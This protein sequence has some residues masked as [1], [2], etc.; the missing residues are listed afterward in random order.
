MVHLLSLLIGIVAGLRAMIAPAAVSWAA[1]L[2]WLR[3]DGTPLAFLGYAWT[4]WVFSV[5][6]IGELI[7]DKLPFTPSRTVPAQFGTRILAGAF[8]GAAFGAMHGWIAVGAIL[9]AIGSIIGTLG[10][11]AARR[12]LATSFGKDRPAA[13][14]EDIVAIV[15]AVFIVRALP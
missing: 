7:T 2:G 12:A 4:P 14:L 13:L 10:G 5:L 9:G 8:A 1:H 6:A 15:A 3:V 11:R